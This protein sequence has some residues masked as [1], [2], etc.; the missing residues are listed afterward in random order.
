MKV[1]NRIKIVLVT[2]FIL[3]FST[4]IFAACNEEEIV[5]KSISLQGYKTEFVCGEEFEVG[6]LVV[7]AEYSDDTK[8][9]VDNYQIDSSKYNKNV[10]GTYVIGCSYTE[11]DVTKTS[12]YTVKVVATY[13]LTEIEIV[14]QN[15]YFDCGTE[16][17]FG[18]GV[19]KKVYSDG[20]KVVTRDYEID[21]SNYD[22]NVAG[23]YDIFVNCGEQQAVY[24]VSVMD[25]SYIQAIAVS[26]QRTKY[27]LGQDFI[28]NGTVSVS[29]TNGRPNDVVSD[30]KY[31]VN[32]DAY[33]KNTLGTY[34]IIVSIG[35]KQCTFN[36]TV[37]EVKSLKILMIGNSYSDDT[38][39]YLP[40]IAKDF[41]FD[42]V[43]F[44]VLYIGGCNIQKHYE[45]SQTGYKGYE[46][47]YYQ[48]GAWTK[49]Y[50]NELKSLEY[51][52]TFKDW[53]YITLQQSSVQSGVVSSYG[54][55]LDKLITYVKQT[56]TN[57]NMQL[58]W[59]MTWAYANDYSSMQKNGYSNQISMYNLIA[60][61][62]ETKIATNMNFVAISPAGTA[63]QNARTSILG[64]TLNRD[65]T[66][67]TYDV[68]RYIAAMSMFCSLTG[69]TVDD[70]T[71]VPDGLD[72][73]R[74]S[75]A[76]DSV[77]NALANKYEVT[78]F[79]N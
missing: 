49:K 16:F 19:V 70:I 4:A 52:V 11:N 48:N 23:E 78:P 65:G 33:N 76:K 43:E 28:F 15:L 7:T 67:L 59:N 63:V 36:V 38:A 26:D 9:A 68:G 58:I 6:D 66:H 50:G 79:K 1:L 73:T 5:L 12:E 3:I 20:I 21:S 44:G 55:S 25:E 14:G 17:S 24:T 13:S 39:E 41:D 37:E 10:A 42:E 75:I 47:R 77:R 30:A 62:V 60:N 51:G 56:A 32:S 29:Y 34:A 46:F 69:Y 8:K 72:E 64:D 53:D 40:E 61:A 54:E 2:L 22:A 31:I 74:I 57:V 35:E 71:Y 45:N 18:D 27:T